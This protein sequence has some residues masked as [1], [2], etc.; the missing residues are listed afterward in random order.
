MLTMR[1]CVCFDRKVLQSNPN[2]V[3]QPVIAVS[4]VTAVLGA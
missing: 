3:E 4:D 1:F 2:P